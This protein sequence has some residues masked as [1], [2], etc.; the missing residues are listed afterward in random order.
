M[1]VAVLNNSGNVGKTTVARHLLAPR[2]GNCPILFVETINEGGDASQFK[3][4]D[5]RQVLI[6]LALLD[7]AV[8]DIGSSNIES[9]FAQLHRLH[10]AH[11]DFDFYVVP[12]VSSQKQ[13]RDTVNTLNALLEIGVE[14]SRIKLVFN[15]V[16]PG[17]KVADV[18]PDL[19]AVAKANGMSTEAVIHSNE[20]YPL[21]GTRDLAE[22]VVNIAALKELAAKATD[23]DE[24]RK[25]ATAVS[26]ARL[27]TGAKAE[28]DS[29]FQAMFPAVVPA[30]VSA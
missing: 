3:G 2:M 19:V 21:I 20:V 8:V 11:E 1:K 24:K 29:V 26:I 6:E 12:T 27:A 7:S 18:F 15:M 9:V 5:F 25:L 23:Q 14:T 28:L 10:D 30:A 4:R 17:D 13:Q 22:N 16:E